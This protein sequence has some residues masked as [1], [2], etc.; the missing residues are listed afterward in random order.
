MY[1]NDLL[2][3]A[4][5][6]NGEHINILPKM[7]NR[8]GLVAGATGTG[9]TVT[10]KVLAESFSEAGVPVFIADVKGDVSGMM[11]PG[12]DSENMQKRIERFGLAEANFTYKGYPVAIWDLFGKSG[13]PLRTTVSEVGPLLMS[14]ILELNDLQSDLLTILYK[15]ADDNNLLL[16]DTKDLKSMLR[17][18]GEHAD[19]FSQEYGKISEASLDVITRSI[20]ALEMNGGD[21]FFGEPNLDV[22]DW[23]ATAEDGRGIIQILDSSSLIN[24]GKLYSTFLLWMMAELFETLPEAGDLDK[25]KMIFFFDEAHL[26]FSDTSKALLE[27]VEQVVKLIR[28][29]GVGIY[30]CTQNPADIPSGVLSQ[31]G[32]KVQHALR[33]FTPAEQK[34][35]KAAADS[36]RANPDFDSKTVLTEL[37]TGEALI[38][39]L[40]EKGTPN[41]VQKGF[42]LPP[43]CSMGA[44]SD[45]EREQAIKESPLFS[46]YAQAVDNVSAYESLRDAAEAEAAAQATAEAEAAAAEAEAAA[47]A[48]A[49]ENASDKPAAKPGSGKPAGKPKKPASS[50]SS[51]SGK[52]PAKPK[53]PKAARDAGRSAAGTVGR[54]IGKEIFGKAFGKKAA[55]VGGNAGA[56]FA[57]GLLD[58]FLKR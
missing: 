20:V 2:W 10:L 44:A 11:C 8:H 48:A 28:S 29:K 34:N 45:A 25:P 22:S 42:I 53:V 43:Q 49:S 5:T 39:F 13:I 41:I 12:Q 50:S 16:I 55:K 3:I 14:R 1:T 6:E 7:A 15:I 47:Q 4:N 18:V 33:A 21:V 58:T 38:S 17:F 31:L 40:D 32:N 26:L 52:K 27:K 54:E 46:K 30:F 23:F 37:G 51:G 57:R 9:K 35:I 56:A 36:F 24:N 19:E